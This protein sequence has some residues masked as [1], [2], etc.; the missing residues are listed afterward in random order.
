MI[1]AARAAGLRRDLTTG[2]A[3][4]SAVGSAA[5]LASPLLALLAS[6]HHL[7]HM[8]VIGA[9]TG[10]AGMSFMTDYPSVRRAMLVISLGAA[11][12]G[13]YRVWRRPDSST[14]QLTTGPSFTLT[15]ALAALAAW[16][17]V[18]FGL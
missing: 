15:A 10:S 13:L 11:T 17:I 9:A 18:Q 12:F 8:L 4:G 3:A 14:A 6:Q 2:S 1:D 7:L 5:G 16:S